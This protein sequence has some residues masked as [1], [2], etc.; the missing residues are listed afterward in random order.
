M[1]QFCSCGYRASQAYGGIDSYEALG[2]NSGERREPTA[3]RFI[4]AH[5]KDCSGTVTDGGR[6][7]G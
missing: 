3:R 7:R 2:I 6:G 1:E 4:G 5:Q